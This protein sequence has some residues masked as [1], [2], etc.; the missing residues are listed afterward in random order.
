MLYKKLILPKLFSQDPETAHNKAINQL[1]RLGNSKLLRTLI[2]TFTRIGA[3][4]LKQTLLGLTFPNPVGLA[5]GFDKSGVA[6]PGL[7]ALGF[8]FIEAG[9]VTREPQVGNDK[10]RMFRL[11][12]EGALINRMGFNNPGAKQVAANLKNARKFMRVP[13]GINIGKTRSIPVDNL[14]L[15]IADYTASATF[16]RN[17]AD[18]FV[19]NLSSP[20]TPGLRTLQKIGALTQ[21]VKAIRKVLLGEELSEDMNQQVPLLVKISPDL[22]LDEVCAIGQL[23]VEMR[24]GIVATNTTLQRRGLKVDPKIEGGMSGKPLKRISLCIVRE[25]RKKFPSLPIIGVGGIFSGEDAYNMLE[26]GANL[27]QVYTGLVFEGPLLPRTLSTHI[28]RR[29]KDERRSTVMS[30]SPQTYRF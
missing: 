6:G 5:A 13:V 29:L 27:I 22:E 1:I 10:P 30:L 16:F 9:G 18:F 8:G 21:I 25:L 28:V 2:E 11:T 14:D 12:Q 26:A 19:I 24:F 4:S 20:N 3:T 23:A 17:I 7:Q 15:V